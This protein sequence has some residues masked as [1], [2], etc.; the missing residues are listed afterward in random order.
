MSSP[1]RI[2][3]SRSMFDKI[4]FEVDKCEIDVQSCLL[5]IILAAVRT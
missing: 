4:S 1:S 5:N 3:L 2:N